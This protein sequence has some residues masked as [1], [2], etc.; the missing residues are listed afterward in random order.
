MIPDK[1]RI[2]LFELLGAWCDGTLDAAARRRLEDFLASDAAAR[3]AYI[4]YLDMHARLYW[5]RRS[6]S[7]AASLLTA[8]GEQSDGVFATCCEPD[9][10][11]E[12]RVTR[13]GPAT[14]RSLARRASSV[15]PISPRGR[16]LLHNRAVLIGAVVA[17]TSGPR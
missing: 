6:P 15:R 16:R 3:Q 1:S 7:L 4:E 11:V 2:E 14:L 5:D 9:D 8:V 13:E 10:T 17:S 12:S